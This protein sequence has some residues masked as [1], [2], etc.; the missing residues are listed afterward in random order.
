MLNLSWK[1]RKAATPESCD[2]AGATLGGPS[3]VGYSVSNL[4]LVVFILLALG[5]A[6]TRV[7]PQGASRTLDLLVIWLALPAVVFVQISALELRADTLAP[8]AFA[9]FALAVS[10]ACVWIVGRM[11]KWSQRTLGTMLVVVPLGNTSFFGLAAVKA[12]LGSAYVGPA[13]VYDQL[14]GFLGLATWASVMAARYGRG[15]SPS[16]GAVLHRL[17]AFPPFI[18]L[19]VA[20]LVRLVALPNGALQTL[21]TIAEPLAATL[22]PLAMLATGMRLQWPDASGIREPLAVGLVVRM[23][24]APAAV[25]GVLTWVHSGSAGW[26]PPSTASVLEAAMPPMVTAGVLAS[27]A[28]LDAELAAA[29]VGVGVILAFVTVPVWAMLLM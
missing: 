13:I 27:E 19:L 22:V 11:R 15:S 14:G 29:L 26:D 17:I 9:W 12:L 6:M 5:V 20:L 21:C 8:S 2:L 4:M 1:V 3:T 7:L 24:V 25:Y 10:A 28:G 23:C 18:A 16:I